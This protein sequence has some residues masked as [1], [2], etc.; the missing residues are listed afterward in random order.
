MEEITTTRALELLTMLV[1]REGRDTVKPCRYVEY[2]GGTCI[3]LCL[4]G[5]LF[6][7][8][9]VPAERMA[10]FG[11]QTVW[12]LWDEGKLDKLVDLSPNAASVLQH[13]QQAQDSR[14]SWGR[15]LA[16]ARRRAW[17]LGDVGKN[18]P[19]TPRFP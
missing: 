14:H 11:S 2:D 17:Y 12:L 18:N 9:G 16:A 3:P 13:A 8:L 7:E 6:V 19:P 10:G 1:E 5:C 4:I 15:A